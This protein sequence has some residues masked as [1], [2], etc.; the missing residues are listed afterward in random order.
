[1]TQIGFGIDIGGSGIKGARVN[2]DTGEFI[3]DR[4]KIL[5]PKPAT[6]QAV[7]ET[8]REILKQAQWNG[9]VG[10]TMPSVIKN[11]IVLSAANIDS[12][13]IDTDVHDLFA[14][15]VQDLIGQENQLIVL[16]DADA[17]GL[18]EVRYGDPQ[19]QE[20]AVIM[21]TFGTGIGSAF[22]MNGVLFPNTE[23]GHIKF[24]DKDAENYAASSAKEREDLSYTEWA[25][26]V[27]KVLKEYEKL[28][29]P[30]CFIVGGGISRKHD[31]WVPKLT[32]KTPVI[33]AQLKNKAGIIGAALAVRQGIKP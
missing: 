7:A 11:Q 4:I 17:A 19:I 13:W 15:Y 12:S 33:P 29:N 6:P 24:R 22:L 30:R 10:I 32:C 27:S 2:L 8:V 20:G 16:N 25:K 1:M 23:I 5:T 28:F 26:R 18:A 21:L 9:P 31:K 3:G 14:Q